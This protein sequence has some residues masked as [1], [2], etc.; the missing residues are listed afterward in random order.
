MRTHIVRK[1][2]HPTYDEL[3]EYSN[4]QPTQNKTYSI[5]LS[6]VTYDTF[7]RDEILGQIFY[8]IDDWEDFNS[9]EL[10]LTREI[11]P[12]HVQVFIFQLL[13]F[14]NFN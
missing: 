1:N 8:L 5:R 9:T 2:L 13:F 10:I 6:L 12:R 14:K 7:T 4:V 3:F 11:T